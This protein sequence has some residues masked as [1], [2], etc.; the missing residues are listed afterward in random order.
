MLL[1]QDSAHSAYLIR[2]CESGRIKVNDSIYETSFIL[3]SQTLIQP[4]PVHHVSELNDT[5]LE[6]LLTLEPEVII[7]GTGDTVQFPE[8]FQLK[9]IMARKIG[10]EVMN[11]ASA[12]RTFNVLCAENRRV[13]AG[14]IL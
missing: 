9:S 8:G 12:C 13:V 6:S 5:T 11:N 4:W 10:Y 3:S 1:S 14:F 2:S 7:I